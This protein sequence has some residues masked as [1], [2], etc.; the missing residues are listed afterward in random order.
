MIL[1]L[2]LILML[3]LILILILML[4][5]LLTLILIGHQARP[6]HWHQHTGIRRRQF[7]RTR[8]RRHPST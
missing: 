7:Q 8:F 3:I 4:M 5:L 1:T 2:T 6:S